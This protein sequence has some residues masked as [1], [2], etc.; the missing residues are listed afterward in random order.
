MWRDKGLELIIQA[1]QRKLEGK[2]YEDYL[3]GFDHDH[4]GHLTPAEFRLSLLALR[5]TQL[6]RP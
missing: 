4:D 3:K 6:S 1:L 5:E 2:T